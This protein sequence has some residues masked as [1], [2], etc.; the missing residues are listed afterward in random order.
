MP[1]PTSQLGLDKNA[2]SLL[3]RHPEASENS[4]KDPIHKELATSAQGRHEAVPSR[5]LSPGADAGG[6]QRLIPEA[7]GSDA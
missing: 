5:A 3:L 2:I 1:P 6:G 7:G 4:R